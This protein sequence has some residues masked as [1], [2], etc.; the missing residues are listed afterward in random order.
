MD[1]Q[2]LEGTACSTVDGLTRVASLD[3]PYTEAVVARFLRYFA[4]LGTPNL[5]VDMLIGEIEAEPQ[6]AL[7]PGGHS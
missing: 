6:A 7:A 5:D 1:L 3:S 4:R 2:H